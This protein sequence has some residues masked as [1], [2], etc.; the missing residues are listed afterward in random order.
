MQIRENVY[1]RDSLLEAIE[2]LEGEQKAHLRAIK[3]DMHDAYE[4]LKPA[5]V[6]R[7]L[8]AELFTSPEI[9][10]DIFQSGVGL[11]AGV[12]AKKMIVGKPDNVF[13]RIA[14]HLIQV[15]VANMVNSNEEAIES[16]GR[17]LLQ[18]LFHRYGPDGKRADEKTGQEPIQEERPDNISNKQTDSEFRFLLPERPTFRPLRRLLLPQQRPIILFLFP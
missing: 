18:R 16:K 12:L 15:S 9:R 4:S 1:S 10:K 8:V 7:T 14:G 17:N 2:K 6:L 5:N 13:K 11:G 3:K